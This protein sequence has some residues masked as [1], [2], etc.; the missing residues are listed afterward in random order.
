MSYSITQLPL[1]Q[2]TFYRY[3]I[4]LEGRQRNFNFYWNEREGAW[5]FDIAN[6]DGVSVIRG[7]KIVP[8]HP[9]GGDYRLD[10]EFLTGY[11]LLLP[12]NLST[13]VDP[14]DSTV[15]P[16]FFKFYYI[17]EVVE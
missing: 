13:K 16:Q 7:Q 11:F 15:I 10:A 12:N 14:L 6:A 1:Y 4:N 9:I 17:Y 3:S 5:H 8:Q 2:E